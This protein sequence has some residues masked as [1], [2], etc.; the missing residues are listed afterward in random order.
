MPVVHG[1]WLP[2]ACRRRILGVLSSTLAQCPHVNRIAEFHLHHSDLM[3]CVLHLR[4]SGV[5]AEDGW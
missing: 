2:C 1:M 4:N 3:A 5:T